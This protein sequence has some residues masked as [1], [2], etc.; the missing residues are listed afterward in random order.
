MPQDAPLLEGTAAA[1]VERPLALRGIGARERRRRAGALLES[2]GL[3]ELAH[4]HAKALS[5]GES[6]RVALARAL[7][8]DPAALLLDE[9]FNGVDDPARERLVAEIRAG[10][11]AAGRTLVLVTQRRDEALRLATRLIVIWQGVVRQ[12]GP[13]EDVLAR[14][15]DT[16]VARFL[17]LDNVL[18]GR[19]VGD[20]GDGVIVDLL[21]VALHVLALPSLRP[22]LGPDVWV[23][24]SPEQV[25]LRAPSA[26]AAGSPRNIVPARVARVL[27]RNKE[28]RE[29][30]SR[31]RRDSPA[32]SRSWPAVTR[33]A[34]EE[35]AL[36]PG[37][38]VQ[39]V[40]K[41]TALHVVPA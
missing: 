35:L 26:V 3:A 20:D 18:K 21:G 38:E 5:G 39:I 1:N 16:D 17:G 15:A 36:Q 6:R 12:D 40:L 28:G 41:A 37:V 7:V 29:S 30:R 13:I 23:V 22:A 33:S 4:R 27:P 11:R 25:E 2:M 24:F 32:G 8:T 10:A 9:P 19:V 14:P 31:W 34:V